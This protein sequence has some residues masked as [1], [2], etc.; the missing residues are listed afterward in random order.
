MLV[1]HNP[2][3]EDLAAELAGG[4]DPDARAALA[5]KYPTGGLAT[6][7]FEG[8]GGS[9]AQKARHWRRSRCRDGSGRAARR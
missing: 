8:H 2:G 6:L 5:A 1:G 9:L 4:G 3:L 7:A